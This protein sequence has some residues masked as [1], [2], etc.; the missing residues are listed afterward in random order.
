MP[1]FSMLALPSRAP[2]VCSSAFVE[3]SVGIRYYY[4]LSMGTSGKMDTRGKTSGR[5]AML[6]GKP[7]LRHRS[8]PELLVL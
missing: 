2:L 5:I 6:Y 8:A 1:R 4:A 7:A 3:P